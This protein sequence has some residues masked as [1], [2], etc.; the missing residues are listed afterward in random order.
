MARCQFH[1]V[2]ERAPFSRRKSPIPDPG[3]RQ[4]CTH[5]HSRHK[6]VELGGG[7]LTCGGDL[8]RC[9]LES[10]AEYL[11]DERANTKDLK[12]IRAGTR[13]AESAAEE[14]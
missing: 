1:K 4:L 9:Q 13:L 3:D 11:D 10:R 6:R 5:N 14:G 2:V 12:A 8:N 7:V